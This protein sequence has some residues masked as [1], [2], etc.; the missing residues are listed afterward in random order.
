MTLN[1]EEKSIL[2]QSNINIADSCNGTQSLGPVINLA[3][4]KFSSN[5]FV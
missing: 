1:S 4:Q 5:G 3:N 2:M